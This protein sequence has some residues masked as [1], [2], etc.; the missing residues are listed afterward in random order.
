MNFLHA[1]VARLTLSFKLLLEYRNALRR[2]HTTTSSADAQ[3]LLDADQRCR[4]VWSLIQA[5]IARDDT[6]LANVTGGIPRPVTFA[7]YDAAVTERFAFLY[8]GEGNS[9]SAKPETDSAREKSVQGWALLL[10]FIRLLSTATYAIEYTC[11]HTYTI[12]MSQH[13]GRSA[14]C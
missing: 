13:S 11:V 7:E 14:L 4:D 5:A 9:D 8:G 10:T 1:V 2:K 3:K 12:Q 6:I